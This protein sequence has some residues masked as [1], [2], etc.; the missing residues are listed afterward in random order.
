MG[1]SDVLDVFSNLMLI[2]DRKSHRRSS[3]TSGIL[4][5][6][7]LIIGIVWFFIELNSILNLLSTFLFLLLFIGIGLIASL[8]NVILT[9]RL[10]L[11]EQFTKKDYYLIVSSTCLLIISLGSF[12]NRNYGTERHESEQAVV[13]EEPANGENITT[14]VVGLSNEKVRLRISNTTDIAR[15]LQKGDS[16]EIKRTVGLLGFDFISNL[17]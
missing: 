11:I 9:Y 7:L 10:K 15:S 16:M 13:L 2:G 3:S 6:I 17:E 12:V 4:Y 8:G 14:L 1:F 5:T